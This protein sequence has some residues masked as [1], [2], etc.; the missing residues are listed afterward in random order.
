MLD[1][2][3]MDDLLRRGG[4]VSS[5]V[6]AWKTLDEQRRR[7]QGELDGLRQ[8]RNAANDKMAKLDK[9]GTEFVAARDELKHL[10]AI[11]KTKEGE[12][13]TLEAESEEQL[14]ALPNAPHASVPDGTS[15][16]DNPVLHTWGHKPT[17]PFAPKPHWEIGESLGILDFA[18]GI[19]I[20]GA[21]F[22]VLRGAASRLTRALINYM[23]D[24]HG[25]A[26]YDEVW[27]PAVVKR[28][29]LRGTGQLP[30]F[31]QDLFKLAIPT[32]PDHVADNDLFLSPTAEV[33]LT[34]LY[35]DHIFEPGEL[36]RR[37]TAYSACFRAEA[38][39][40]GK[41]TR[42]LI[43]QH[44]F[45]KVELVKFVEPQHSDGELE[46]LRQDAERVLQGLGL[47]YRV[48]TLCTAD[49]SFASAK[50][51]DLEVWLPGQ[52]TYREISSCSNFEDFQARRA[53]IRY[54]PATGDK[55]RPC[56]TLNGSG[57]AIGRTVVAI[58]EQYQQADGTVLVPS[59]L[60]PYMGGLERITAGS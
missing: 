24:L 31:E 28:A 41:D 40:A 50:T 34:N 17:F 26:G 27:P 1:P 6:Q 18:A 35:S 8:Q 55:P 42:G 60:R 52:D 11:I 59:A 37:F 36:P 54:R 14:L 51:Y 47:H 56:H 25:A 45:D 39:A 13:G 53:K 10:S 9:K 33:Q 22:T 12:L 46:A 7:L 49:L 48:V 16:A 29:S 32:G 19:T 3:R 21:R 38:G 57:I 44:Q 58:L 43:R 5:V 30:K 20:T 4:E 15:E 2:S 23:L